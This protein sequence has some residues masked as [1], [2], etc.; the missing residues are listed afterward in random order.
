MADP[1]ISVE[2]VYATPTEQVLEHL[3]VEHDA[4]VESVIQR[5]GVLERHPE[6]DLSVNKVGIFG[7]AAPLTGG[8]HDGDR[9]EIYR[10]LIADPKEARKK[11]AAQGKSMKKGDRE[12][13]AKDGGS[14]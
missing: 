8:L 5:S 14:R 2:V 7:K 4:T 9:I 6:I 13:P 11:R 3:Q 10:P 1:R 12:T